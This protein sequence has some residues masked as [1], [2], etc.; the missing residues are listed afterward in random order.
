MAQNGTNNMKIAGEGSVGG[1]TYG[2]VTI[3]GAGR[4]TGD[5]TSDDFR[6]NGAGSA[7]GNVASLLIDI[8]GTGSFNGKVETK[9]MNIKGDAT[10]KQGLGVS[11]LK[12]KGRLSAGGIAAN[13]V[14]VRGEVRVKANLEAETLTGEGAFHVDGT[15]NVGTL[16]FALHGLSNAREIGGDKVRVT[17]GRGFV[18]ASL[19]GL[20]TDRRLNVET[21]EA[22]EIVLENT[23]ARVV[24]GGNVRIGSGCDVALVEYS[25][26]IEVASDARVG[27]SRQVAKA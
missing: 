27:E 22:D 15:M 8:N 2:D 20:F 7:D 1:G 26:T 9:E 6:I 12:V 18:G 16:D 25:G 10:V 3:N 14:D 13:I 24:R 4:V 23:T 17:L 21:V 11:D 5:I 19:V